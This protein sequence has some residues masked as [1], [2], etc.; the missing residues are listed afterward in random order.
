M[1]NDFVKKCF[2]DTCKVWFP[3][4]EH[5]FEHKSKFKDNKWES[6]FKWKSKCKCK[7]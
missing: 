6:K 5:K 1:I 4:C 3:I 7:K 2:E